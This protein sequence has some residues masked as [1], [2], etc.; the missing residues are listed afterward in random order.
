M[1]RQITT[2][3]V[4]LMLLLGMG[5]SAMAA[6]QPWQMDLQPAATSRMEQLHGF[7]NY[8]LVIITAISV[9]VLILL[10]WVMIRYN[11]KA[12]PTPSKLTH[13]TLLEFAWTIIPILILA[14]IAVPSLRILYYLDDLDPARA[15]VKADLTI[16]AIGNQWN[17]SY[18]YPD[19]GGFR[20]TATML[21]DEGVA[22]PGMPTRQQVK[23][24]EPRL[25]AVDNN[26]VVPVG[27][28]VRM[29]VTASDV[30]HSWAVPAFGVKT[31]GVPGRLNETW[32]KVDKEGIYYGQCSELCGARHAFMPIAVEVVSEQRF[33]EWVA[34]QQ[35]AAGIVPEVSL[36]T[37]EAEGR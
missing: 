30:I 27:K 22:D 18:E 3:T 34:E 13:S 20:F 24:G 14:S 29:Q 26:I 7:N 8:L 9:F 28:V 4:A 15:E 32:F 11:A 16:K 10:L 36:A 1:K 35:A 23:P 19:Q 31:D 33:K 6:P 21:E 17:W 5:W 12:N 37:A 2:I 25:L